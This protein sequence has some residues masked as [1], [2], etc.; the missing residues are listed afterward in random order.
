M[1]TIIR[2]VFFRQTPLAEKLAEKEEVED[3]E[4]VNL[5][6]DGESSQHMYV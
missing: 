3:D 2:D 6:S 4:P 1:Q 5:C